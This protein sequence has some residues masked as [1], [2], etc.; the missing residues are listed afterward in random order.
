MWSFCSSSQICFL[1]HYSLEWS[2]N[3]LVHWVTTHLGSDW[4][5]AWSDSAKAPLW[6]GEDVLV[7]L[8]DL[9]Y[10]FLSWRGAYLEVMA[11]EF[12]FPWL[13]VIKKTNFPVFEMSLLHYFTVTREMVASGTT[14][15]ILC[16]LFPNVT[17]TMWGL[18]SYI[19]CRFHKYGWPNNTSQTSMGAMSHNTSSVKGLM[20]FRRWHCWLMC[21]S[22]PWWSHLMV[23]DCGCV[24]VGK[25][26]HFITSVAMRFFWILLSTMKCSGEPFTHI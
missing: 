5:S 18:D 11:T 17:I 26:S 13:C 21:R 20:L 19:A 22:C 16:N 8:H 6:G 9:F 7:L 23:Y 25:P 10:F 4:W 3:R 2:S 1:I 24:V 14:F 15:G 12:L